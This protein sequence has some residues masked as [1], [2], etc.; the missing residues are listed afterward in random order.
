MQTRKTMKTS[1][2]LLWT[3]IAFTLLS[4]ASVNSQGQTNR[5]STTVSRGHAHNDYLHQRP[6]LDALTNGFTSVEADVF[7]ADNDLLLGHDRSQLRTGRTLITLYLKPL[8]ERLRTAGDETERNSDTFYLLVDFKTDGA[9]AYTLL[10]EQLKPYHSMLTEFSNTS[11]KFNAITIIITGNCPIS[12]IARE[13]RRW[14]ACDGRVSDLDRKPNKHLMPWISDNW[15]RHFK[16][17]GK[18]KMPAAEQTKLKSLVQKA[19]KSAQL[20]R[21]WAAPDTYA[22]WATQQEACVDL[23]NTDRLKD[24][25][26]FSGTHEDSP[27]S[28]E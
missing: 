28:S 8:V 16:W 27:N 11:T 26:R 3:L 2:E 24:F 4:A 13:K 9:K 14:V 21:F 5:P 22:S 12:T 10:K 25:G 6:L 23:I 15:R 20:I 7:Q 1:R 19:H 18:G 17:N